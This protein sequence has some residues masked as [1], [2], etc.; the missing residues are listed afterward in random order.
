MKEKDRLTFGNSPKVFTT[1]DGA[2]VL[3][4]H[5]LSRTDDR[6]GHSSLED[7]GVL[8]GRIVVRLNL[9]L[10]DTDALGGD[11]FANLRERSSVNHIPQPIK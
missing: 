7:T 5:V 6:E 8:S 9:G 10:V 4:R 1:L 2:A 3:G 11:D